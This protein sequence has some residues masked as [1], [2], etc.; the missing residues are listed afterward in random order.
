MSTVENDPQVKSLS[1][2]LDLSVADRARIERARSVLFRLAHDCLLDEPDDAV[3]LVDVVR[4]LMKMSCQ[5]DVEANHPENRTRKPSPPATRKVKHIFGEGGACV[6]EHVKGVACATL[7]Q[8]AKRGTVAE[9]P[10][11][12]LRTLP[13]P[14]VG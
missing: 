2:S 6:I 9:S 13:I 10:P 12:D 5:Y 4:L 14:G 11:V 1:I 7:R 3:A 8:R